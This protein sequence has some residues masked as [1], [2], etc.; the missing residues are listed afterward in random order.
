VLHVSTVSELTLLGGL[1]AEALAHGVRH[2][3]CWLVGGLEVVVVVGWSLRVDCVVKVRGE[4]SRDILIYYLSAP[5]QSY[6]IC[7]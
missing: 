2:V 3:D 5:W 1:L 6:V 4:D 7:L